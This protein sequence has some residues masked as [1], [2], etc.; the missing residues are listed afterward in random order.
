[1]SFLIHQDNETRD[2][3]V[4]IDFYDHQIDS[5]IGP[6]KGTF[7]EEDKTKVPKRVKLFILHTEYFNCER[8][9]AINFKLMDLD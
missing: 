2:Y 5:L 3:N 1:M 8:D 9:C 7:S 6:T 4:S